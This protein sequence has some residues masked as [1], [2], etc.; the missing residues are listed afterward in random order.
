VARVGLQKREVPL[1]QVADHLRQRLVTRP[2][3]RKGTTSRPGRCPE[4]P[5]ARCAR[6]PGCSRRRRSPPLRRRRTVR[7]HPRR[8]R[9]NQVPAGRRESGNCCLRY[10]R[11][12]SL[13]GLR[14]ITE[15]NPTAADS[16]ALPGLEICFN[17]SP[18]TYVMGFRS[19]GPPGLC[20]FSP[21]RSD[22]VETD[23][24]HADA[25]QTPRKAIKPRDREP[26]NHPDLWLRKSFWAR[27]FFVDG[28]SWR[29]CVS[30]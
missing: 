18:L 24:V 17:P 1:S 7:R 26:S 14:R 15:T 9:R 30:G 25:K 6:A 3:P 29:L 11:T 12:E 21:I 19:F 20:S 28:L 8:C 23:R 10:S 27:A 16:V 22:S 2:E 4:C 13:S 5:P